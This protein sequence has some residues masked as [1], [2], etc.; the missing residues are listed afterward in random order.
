ML[1]LLEDGNSL[2]RYIRILLLR[3]EVRSLSL[4]R[5]L[6]NHITH[7]YTSDLHSYL[8]HYLNI[9]ALWSVWTQ[10]ELMPEFGKQW[11][12]VE[13]VYMA[14]WMR[15]QIFGPILVLQGV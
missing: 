2:K 10:F 3:M 13:G 4:F 12:P 9:V 5:L 1:Q 6:I 11:N 15:Y 7:Y 14:P 8:R